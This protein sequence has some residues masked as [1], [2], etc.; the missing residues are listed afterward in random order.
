MFVVNLMKRHNFKD[1]LS[2]LLLVITI[3]IMEVDNRNLE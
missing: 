3:I 2:L 1:L